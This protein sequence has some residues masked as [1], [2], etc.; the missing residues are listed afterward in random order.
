[1]RW[2]SV[3]GQVC[4]LASA[5]GSLPLAAFD[6]FLVIL[7]GPAQ[8][9]WTLG[10]HLLSSIHRLPERRVPWLR[11]PFLFVGGHGSTPASVSR[12]LVPHS[13]RPKF[14]A[15]ISTLCLDTA[16]D[17]LTEDLGGQWVLLSPV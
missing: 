14:L 4:V 16:A 1:M 10:E 8:P 3:H 9:Q 13:V 7:V 5:H 15:I 17:E 12:S 11:C 6:H 2:I